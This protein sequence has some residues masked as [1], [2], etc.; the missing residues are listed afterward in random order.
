LSQRLCALTYAQKAEVGSWELQRKINAT[1]YPSVAL[2][3]AVDTTSIKTQ[4]AQVSAAETQYAK[5]LGKGLVDPAV[6]L[7]RLLSALK[8]AGEDKV[9]AEVQRQLTTWAK[10]K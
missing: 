8:A 2:G 1:A 5:L 7:P 10:T 6:G 3:F 4:I 9:I